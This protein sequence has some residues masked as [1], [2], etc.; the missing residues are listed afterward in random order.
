VRVHT[1]VKG[2]G[3][4]YDGGKG[5]VLLLS[6]LEETENIVTDD[7]TDLAVKLLKDTHDGQ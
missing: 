2:R 3:R 4:A 5:K 7:D 6:V 1:K